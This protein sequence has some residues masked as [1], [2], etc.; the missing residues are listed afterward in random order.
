MPATKTYTTQ[1]AA[2]AVMAFSL[3]ND[4]RALGELEAAPAAIAKMLA[5]APTARELAQTL[6]YTDRVLLTGRGY[7]LTTALE[8]ALKLR[9]A[10]YVKA[11]AMSYADLLHGPIAMVDATLRW[12]LSLR[13]RHDVH[14]GARSRG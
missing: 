1:L 7:A 14:R 5:L 6:T 12:C 4:G 10:C 9:E 13:V 3:G 11:I 8:I 2:L